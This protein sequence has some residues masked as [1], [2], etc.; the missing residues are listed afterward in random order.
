MNTTVSSYNGLGQCAFEAFLQ[1][2][3][4]G[5][6]SIAKAISFRSR[7]SLAGSFS[8][9]DLYHFY[10]KNATGGSTVTNQYG[11]YLEALNKGTNNRGIV[12]HGDG[13]GSD[14]IF[15]AGMD[16][17]IYYDGNDLI[18]NPQLVG[19]GVVRVLNMKSGATQ[20]AAGAAA[21]E[22]WKTNG[23]ATLPDNVVMIGA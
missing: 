21:D 6:G 5:A 2:V 4:G 8:F 14:I 19:A 1:G 10:A 15:G 11:I 16:A 20:V 7:P 13:E 17:A 9:T 22:L 23:H 3:S 18:I 12:L